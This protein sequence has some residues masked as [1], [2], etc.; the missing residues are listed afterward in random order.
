MKNKTSITINHSKYLLFLSLI[1]FIEFLILAIEPYNRQDWLLE[2]VLVF[3]FIISFTL[4]YKRYPL[5]KTSLTLIFIFLCLHEIGA[6]YTYAK[7]PY[8]LWIENTFNSSLNHLLGWERNH[9]DRLAHFLYGLLI[10]YPLREIILKLINIQKFWGYFIPLN[11]IIS[12]SVIFELFEWAAAE[13]FGGELGIA[14]LGTQGDVWDAHKD[15]LMSLVGASIA[16]CL[17]L[18]IKRFSVKNNNNTTS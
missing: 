9:F 17:T 15:M 10:F 6:H 3:I 4:T 8:D 14:Y 11:I 18:L 12:T 13:I 16:L 1:F 5:S 7:V 2:N